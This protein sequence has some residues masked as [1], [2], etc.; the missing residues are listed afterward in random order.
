MLKRLRVKVDRS[1][2]RAA[3]GLRRC[4]ELHLGEYK[5]TDHAKVK[6]T[7]EVTVVIM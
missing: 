4:V 3:N 1:L 7:V 2:V 5:D 6:V